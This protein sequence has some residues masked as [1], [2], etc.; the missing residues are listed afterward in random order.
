MTI[1]GQAGAGGRLHSSVRLA[2]FT[3]VDSIGPQA[4]ESPARG[5]AA[6]RPF[7]GRTRE[8]ADLSIAIDAAGSGAGSLVLV[9]GEPGIGK[10][11]LIAE[12]AHAAAEGGLTMASGRCWEEG[13]APP[14]WPWIQVLRALGGDLDQLAAAAEA[15]APLPG[16]TGGITPEG[17]RIRLFDAVGR[18]LAHAAADRPLLVTLDDMHAA[19][20]P[21]LLLLRF[22]AE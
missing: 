3:S 11:R 17:E 12:L 22:L 5:E 15:R 14:Y 1:N 4:V 2:T 10:T 13:G 20:E 19:D 7:V 9:T 6:H 16:G 8:L 18:F 21:S